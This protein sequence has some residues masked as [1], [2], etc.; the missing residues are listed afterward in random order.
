MKKSLIFSVI[1]LVILTVI[2]SCKTSKEAGEK[3][4]LMNYQSTVIKS[5]PMCDMCSVKIEGELGEMK[6]VRSVRV[7]IPEKTITVKYSPDRVSLDE[8]RNKVASLGYDADDV[9]ADPTVYEQLPTCC[10]KK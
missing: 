1:V 7:S 9:K 5:T 4:G 6:G 2:Y 8:I 3:G 10:K